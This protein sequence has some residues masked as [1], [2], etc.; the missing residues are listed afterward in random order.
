VTHDTAHPDRNR[1]T[2]AIA[3]KTGKT[4]D[5]VMREAVE[6]RAAAAGV[7]VAPRRPFDEAKVLAIIEGVSKLPI[8]DT[9]TDDEIL[10]YNE[11]G[12]WD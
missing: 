8:L 3:I 7:A 1:T 11:N 10:G 2:R 4:P 5:D 6:A 12:L 9:R